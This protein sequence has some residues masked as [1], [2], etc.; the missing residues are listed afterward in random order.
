MDAV[1]LNFLKG[2]VQELKRNTRSMKP[3]LKRFKNK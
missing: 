3:E 1:N 2:S